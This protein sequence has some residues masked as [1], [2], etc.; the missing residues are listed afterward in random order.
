[1]GA[2]LH[3]VPAIFVGLAVVTIPG[4]PAAW[5]LR[6][7]GLTLVAASIAASIAVV[8]LASIASSI[9]GLRWGLVPILVVAATLTLLLAPTRLIRSRTDRR[10]PS[11]STPRSALWAAA[12][13]I[14]AGGLIGQEIA[15]AVGSPEN[16]SQTYDG[17][18]HLNAA[19]HIML[20]GDSSPFNMNLTSPNSQ[21]S[22]YPT[23]WHSF[24]AL[25]AQL[26][27]AS[28]PAATNSFAL[29]VSAWIWPVAILFFSRPFFVRRPAHLV[30]GAILAANFSAFPYLLL[31]W[32]VLYP[33]LLSTA[34]I[35]IALGFIYAALRHRS[36]H[37]R[38]PL[39]SLWVAAIGAVGAA[40]LA[41]PN[42]IFGIAAFTIPM[43]LVTANDVRKLELTTVAKSL[44]F[45]GLGIAVVGYAVIWSVVSTSDNQRN[46]GGN[47]LNAAV[48]GLSNAQM[49]ESRAWFLTILVLGGIATLLVLKRHR[50]L[51][52]SYCIALGLFVVAAGLDGPIRTLFTDPWYNDAHRLATLIPI[53]AIPLAAAAAARLLDYVTAGLEKVEPERVGPRVRPHLPTIGAVVVCALILTG[54]RGGTIPM[55]SGWIS[56]LHE[57][58]GELLSE[59]E[60]VLLDRIA[61]EIPEDAVIVGDPWTGTSL[62]L[63]ISQREVLFPHFGGN[64]GSDRNELALEFV[65]M[66]AEVCPLVNSL[67][68]DYLLDFGA[69]RYDIG[70]PTRYAKYVGLHNV[71][72][73]PVVTEV[74]REGRAKLFAIECD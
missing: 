73:S 46:Y 27:G 28:I 5:I 8:A 48:N 6:F 56:D 23:L 2:W 52:L 30:L 39:I 45:T 25:I 68:V 63:A 67:G 3:A 72:N 4:L 14:V 60:R 50:W 53:G 24:V 13:V 21:G 54:A 11:V 64:Y 17:V 59:D 31:A 51:I 37:S 44:R 20:S 7:R 55:Q 38:A 26:T 10:F 69:E 61:Q 74:D 19:A 47:V 12:A 29:V 1:M 40:S 32:G 9:L 42:A 49:L 41:H 65:P 16:I 71:A 62:A 35:P 70:D 36:V 66:G 43:F 58:A 15:R 57:P 33:N 22:F 18:F 34:L